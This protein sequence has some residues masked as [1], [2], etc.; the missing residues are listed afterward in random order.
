MTRAE[1]ENYIYESFLR[2]EKD[3][4]VFAPDA[5]KRHPEFSKVIIEE[6]FSKRKVPAVTVTG[7][8]GKGSVAYMISQIL[9]A[10]L[11][12]GLMTSPHIEQF[13]ERFRVNGI[14]ITDEALGLFAEKTKA[15]FADTDRR[16]GRGECISPIGLQ[17]AIALQFFDQ[18]QTDINIFEGGKGVQYDDVNNIPHEYAV[19]NTIF[20]EHT[21]ELG[22]TLLQI[23]KDKA[24]IITGEQKCVYVAEQKEEVFTV[25]QERA[26]QKNVELKRYGRDFWAENIRYR[27]NGMLFDAVI[28]N[29][30]IKELFIPLLGQHQ[31][32]NCVLALS[33]C[34]DYLEDVFAI[35]PVKEK[36]Q[37]L[38]WPGRMEIIAQK[39]LTILDACINRESAK[40]V[41]SVLSEMNVSKVVA[42]VGIPDDKDY[43]GVVETIAPI[44]PVIFLTKSINKHYIFTKKQQ[45]VLR[46]QG[47]CV[48]WIDEM[49]QAVIKAGRENLPIVILG[50]TSLISDVKRL[51]SNAE[52]T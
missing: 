20:L 34:I 22:A 44:A 1:A 24:C 13:N 10:F 49:P 48:D 26:I 4:D 5:Q 30:K 19:I 15:L 45:D 27:K 2:A 40:Q 25:L 11:T 17:C 36:L 51:Y 50:T 43:I 12:S 8:K 23:A 52:M 18:M 3:W 35:A 39:P 38:K 47:Y 28:G 31:A 7:S 46:K 14:C 21:R 42:I 6:L 41:V 32:K 33:F 16:L 29:R 9:S 37:S